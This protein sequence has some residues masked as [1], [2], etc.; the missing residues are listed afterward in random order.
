[1]RP[2]CNHTPFTQA[3]RL[4]DGTIVD[5]GLL[6]EPDCDGDSCSYI[7]HFTE[8]FIDA[9]LDAR[10]AAAVDDLETLNPADHAILEDD[11]CIP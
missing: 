11:P 3:A 1:M 4:P 6:V 2:P 9:F 7:L 10:H 8:H 5:D